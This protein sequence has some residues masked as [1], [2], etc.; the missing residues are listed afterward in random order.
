MNNKP[1][2]TLSDVFKTIFTLFRILSV[3]IMFGGF[4]Y[5]YIQTQSGTAGIAANFASVEKA[6]ESVQH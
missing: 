5:A 6:L 3:I 2:S 4:Y 1:S